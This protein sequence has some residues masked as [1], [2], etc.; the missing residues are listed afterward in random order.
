MK[1]EAIFKKHL[2]QCSNLQVITLGSEVLPMLLGVK[3]KE[4]QDEILRERL[5]YLLIVEPKVG[6]SKDEVYIPP[7]YKTRGSYTYNPYW[8]SGSFQATT[9]QSGGYAIPILK[10]YGSFSLTL[11]SLVGDKEGS[12]PVW[13][14]GAQARGNG[15]ARVD[16]LFEL[17]AFRTVRSWSESEM[18]EMRSN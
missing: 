1:T 6:V 17:L 8:G 3:A 14:A 15:F 18:C 12:V 13:L 10:P 2:S 4:K 9:V 16:D 7:T 5:D 11:T